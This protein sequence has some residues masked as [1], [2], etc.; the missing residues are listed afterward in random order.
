MNR[1][2][3]L[4]AIAIA[5]LGLAACRP[6]TPPPPVAPAP[7]APA[8]AASAPAAVLVFEDN[9][10]FAATESFTGGRN[11]Y[12]D[13]CETLARRLRDQGVDARTVLVPVEGFSRADLAAYGSLVVVDS[14]VVLPDVRAVLEEFVRSGGLL[15]GVCEVGRYPGTWAQPWPFGDVF[16]LTTRKTDHY[17]TGVA[18]AAPEFYRYADIQVTNHPFFKGLNAR[19]DWGE[20][21]QHVWAV[22]PAG[23]EVLAAFPHYQARLVEGGEPTTV[24]RSLPAVTLNR[25][26]AGRALFLSILPP[27]RTFDGWSASPDSVALLANALRTAAAPPP[28]PVAAPV[29]IVA[30]WNQVA[31]GPTWPKRVILRVRG[32]DT[33]AAPSGTFDLL[34]ASGATVR[35]GALAVWPGTLWRARYLYADVTD[36]TEPGAY[37]MRLAVAGEQPV[38]VP[39]QIVVGEPARSLLEASESFF[40]G[41][42]CGEVCHTGDPVAGG[43]HDATGDWAVRMWSMPHVLWALSRYVEEHPE[44]EAVRYELERTARWMWKMLGTDGA[45]FASIRPPDDQSPLAIRPAQDRTQREIEKR[46]SFE[47][48]ATYAAAV[49]RSL[50]PVR[51]H[52]SINLAQELQVCAEL[53]YRR[54][55][56][57]TPESTKDMGNRMWA[58]VEL[59]RATGTADYL[60]DAERDARLILPRQLGPGRVV[61]GAVAG[62]FFADAAGTTFSPQQWKRFHGIGMYLGLVE[63][64]RSLPEGSLR[65]DVTVVVDR[66]VND[67][68][69]GMSALSPYGQMAV[70]LEPATPPRPRQDGRGLEPPEKFK[71]MHFSH[72]EAWVRDHGLN[73]DLLAMATVALERYRDTQ[74]PAL[75][76]FAQRQVNWLLGANPLGYCMVEGYGTS[77][78]PT[79][80]PAVGTGLVRGG[81]PNGIIGRGLDNVPAWGTSWDSREYWLPQNA[82]LLAALSLLPAGR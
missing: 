79:V 59:Y 52:V 26:G 24:E 1:R 39:M 23:A 61:D 21:A 46:F 77:H 60:Q 13:Q 67:F 72:R 81:I 40:A 32:G 71:V 78:P 31:Y 49:A 11:V 25:Y 82:Y 27:A 42:R 17:G 54:V 80:D 73:C 15:A 53:A 48:T 74:D 33:N 14:F 16:G 12:I 5:L 50:K 47:Y 38:E 35:S 36:V 29:Q 45:P 30:G 8:P 3:S 34:D 62:D 6:R 37:R 43:Y 28:G 66:F 64:L 44:N 68:L 65:T 70:G 55:R 10:D 58:A 63:L 75:R 9:L 18:A 57:A 20:R 76:D 22:D 7:P 4:C 69:Q 19:I 41:M 56:E 2:A 51:E